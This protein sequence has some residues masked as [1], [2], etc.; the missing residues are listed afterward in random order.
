MGKS[1]DQVIEEF[2]EY[3]NMSADELEEWLQSEDSQGSGWTAGD[4]GDGETVGHN[5][6]RKIVDILR[7]NPSKDAEKYTEE[8]LAHMRK[9]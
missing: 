2:N 4:D 8:D 5:S 9:V 1:D 6:G 3:V 7:R